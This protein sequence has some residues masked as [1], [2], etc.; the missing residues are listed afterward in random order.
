M[1]VKT[2][3]LVLRTVDYGENDKMITL[4]TSDLGKIGAAVKGV[5]KAS[6][7]LKF[8]AQPFCFA[9]YV[10]AERAGR[11]TVTSASLYD[12]FYF[13]REDIGAF[14]AAT[15]VCEACNLLLYEGMVNPELLICAVAAIR[16]MESA[17]VS[18]ALICFL[19]QAMEMAGYPVCAEECPS[20]GKTPKGKLFFDLASGS[21]FCGECAVGTPA[22]ESTYHVLR[23][24]LGLEERSEEENSEG[25]KRALRLL[26]AYFTYQTEGELSALGEY[27]R[28]L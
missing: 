18:R 24:E 17:S 9:E 21:F 5:K 26:K 2:D 1:E 25:E 27:I 4:L 3:A 8:A 16:R 19:M 10:L 7:K 12:G 20:C 22:S 6:A 11:Y 28:L 15:A 13:L 23:Q 14:Y